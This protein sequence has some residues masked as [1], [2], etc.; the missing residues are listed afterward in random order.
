MTTLIGGVS[1]ILSMCGIRH[2]NSVIQRTDHS[3]MIKDVLDIYE[4]GHITSAR[5]IIL[6][7]YN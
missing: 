1:P 4:W 2:R 3:I 6:P 7:S 5:V